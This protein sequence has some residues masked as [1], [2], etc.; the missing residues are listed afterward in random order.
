MLKSMRAPGHDLITG[1]FVKE[2]SEKVFLSKLQYLMQHQ[3]LYKFVLVE[4]FRRKFIML[5]LVDIIFLH[6]VFQHLSL[7]YLC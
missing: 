6:F 7:L 3:K 1:K 5:N 4:K 2:P